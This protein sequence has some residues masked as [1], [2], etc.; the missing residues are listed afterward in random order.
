MTI[1]RGHDWGEQGALAPD[2][3]VVESDAAIIAAVERMPTGHPPEVGL[4]GGDLHRTLGSPRHDADD[5]RAG[6]GMRLPVDVVEVDLRRPDGTVSRHRFASHLVARARPG[7]PF[8]VPTY[9][10]MNGSF[11]GPANLGPRAHPGDGIV[12]ITEGTL[13]RGDRRAARRRL[14]LGTHIPHPDLRTRRAAT[15]EVEFGAVY[16]VSLDGDRPMDATALELR[17][18]PDALVVVV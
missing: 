1:R 15:D 13:P 3:P 4:T 16:E 7:R 5:L 6:S 14:P 17:C 8:E 12:D 18:S 9:V 2:A 11:V 10:A